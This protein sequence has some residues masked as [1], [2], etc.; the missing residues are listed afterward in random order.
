MLK[1]YLSQG[2]KLILN[3]N[4]DLNFENCSNWFFVKQC[5][6]KFNYTGCGTNYEIKLMYL[7][8]KDFFCNDMTLTSFKITSLFIRNYYNFLRYLPAASLWLFII[9][10]VF[11]TTLTVIILIRLFLHVIIIFLLLS[12]LSSSSFVLFIDLFE[13]FTS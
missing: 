4:N 12:I 9:F 6:L 5:W 10:I 7:S 11:V 8:Y 1:N 2:I 3:I 13:A